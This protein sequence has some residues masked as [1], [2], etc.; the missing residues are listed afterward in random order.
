MKRKLLASVALCLLA[1]CATPP[2]T[3]N[4]FATADF[5]ELPGDYHEI[6]KAYMQSRLK[7][8]ESAR[9]DFTRSPGKVWMGN[10]GNRTYGWAACAGINAKNSYGGYTGPQTH[11]FVI[12]SGT[13]V[14]MYSGGASDSIAEAVAQKLC[15]Q[16]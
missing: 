11:Y 9:Y 13:V 3:A 12:K 1:G 15:S 6:I 7:D 16:F 8:P 10:P 14:H 2:P 5:G 4:E